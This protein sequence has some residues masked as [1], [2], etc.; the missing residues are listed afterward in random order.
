MAQPRTERVTLR[1][2]DLC[3][4]LAVGIVGLG[5]IN[6]VMSQ[7]PGAAGVL[8]FGSVA[9]AVLLLAL[10]FGGGL[11]LDRFAQRHPWLARNHSSAAIFLLVPPLLVVLGAIVWRQ[12]ETI[13][14]DVQQSAQTALHQLNT[15]VMGESESIE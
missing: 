5:M 12:R 13:V 15:V 1:G 2:R 8:G 7:N 9:I 4:I 11:M 10:G 14:D 6:I 3:A